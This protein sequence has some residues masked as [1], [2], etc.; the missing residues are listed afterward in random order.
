MRGG[1]CLLAA[2][3][4]QSGRWLQSGLPT[5]VPAVPLP[6]VW[7][8]LGPWVPALLVASVAGI[9]DW[10]YRRIPNWLTVS[11]LVAGIAVNVIVGGWP[12]LKEAL[13]GTLLGLGI[14]LP[15]VLIRSR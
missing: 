1:A 7:M 11:G 6:G 13:L 14:L 10:R 15:F 9:L 4:L 12:G 3:M 5:G 2:I 8:Q